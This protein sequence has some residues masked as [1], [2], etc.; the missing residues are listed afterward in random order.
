[1]CIQRQRR[2]S[3]RTRKRRTRSG[4][5][6]QEKQLVICVDDFGQH[7]YVNEAVYGLAEAG[8]VSA[9]SCLTEAPAWADGA[10]RIREFDIQTGLHINFTQTWA[11]SPGSLGLS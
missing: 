5:A 8:R 1:R 9:T 4:M 2:R 7:P 10:G 11:N 3:R 6:G